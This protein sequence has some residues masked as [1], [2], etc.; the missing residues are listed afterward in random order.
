MQTP[1]IVL[2][3]SSQYR[4]KQL[5]TLGLPFETHAP[6]VDETPRPEELP[7]ALAARL[8]R[9]KAEVVRES[10]PDALIIGSD[11]TAA[12]D[13][14]F[15]MKP[16]THQR[17]V[18]QLRLL[19]GRRVCFYTGLCLYDTRTGDQQLA[20]ERSVVTL[21]DLQDVEIE[22]YVRRD[23]PFDCAGAFRSEGLG[24]A[25]FSAVEG[26]DPTALVGLPL[27]R[28]VEF[29]HNQGVRVLG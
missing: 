6:D 14:T 22:D 12:V 15:L 10:H 4:K 3:S 23:Q 5:E 1:K 7:E 9:A 20:V 8:A 25:L 19:S 28:L 2:A 11:Q 17:A 26:D 24:I 29:L 16:G 13:G 21:R 27:I 18:S